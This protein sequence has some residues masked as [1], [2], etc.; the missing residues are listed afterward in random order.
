MMNPIRTRFS[1][2]L[3]VG[4]LGANVA[5][6]AGRGE[7]IWRSFLETGD[8]A[9]AIE[10]F[11]RT[12]E[13]DADDLMA[14]AGRAYL[15]ECRVEEGETLSAFLDALENG[16]SSPEAP[17]FL[18]EAYHRVSGREDAAAMLERLGALLQRD[19]LVSHV[20]DRALFARAQLLQK[21]GKWSDAETAF[22]ELNFL[23][24]FWVC[25]P[26]DNTEK[27][28]HSQ[29]YGPEESLDLSATS[30]GRRRDV[31]WRPLLVDPYDGYIDLHASVQPAQES[32]VYLAS[33]VNSPSDQR[34]KL[35]LGYAGAVKAWLN[36]V[37][38][39]D[40]NRY[41]AALPDQAEAA[42]ELREG[43]NT[44]LVKVSAPKEGAFGLYARFVADEELSE[45]AL[46]T[47]AQPDLKNDTPKP[48]QQVNDDAFLF[49]ATSIKQLKAFG[50]NA[51]RDPQRTLFYVR[52]LSLLETADQNDQSTNALMGAMCKRYPGNPLLLRHLGD[53][54]PQDNRQRLAYDLV[55]ESDPDDLAAFMGLLNYY[56]NSAYA[57]KG[58]ELIREW[59]K[60]HKV[61]LSARL[62]QAQM[63]RKQ[64]LGEAAAGLLLQ[65][66]ENLGGEGL[67]LL[68]EFLGDSVSRE[69]QLD[70]LKR[71]LEDDPM[72]AEVVHTLRRIALRNGNLDSVDVF[73]KHEN[74]IDPF[75][76]TGL[77]D[78]ALYYQSSGNDEAALRTL[79]D[80]QRI[81]PDD[82]Q[83]HRMTAVANHALGNEAKAL[84]ALARAQEILPSDPWCIDYQEML[85]PDEEN[86]AA[87]YLRDWREVE[88][89][90]SLDLSKANYLT[91]LSQ[92]IVKVFPN[93]NSS[94]T[95]Q[96]AVTVLTD[97]GVRM[98]QVRP[99][100]YEAG[101]EDVVVKRARVHKPDGSAFDAPPARKQSASSA[102]DAQARLYMDYMVA[103]LQFPALEKGCT[104]EL[105]YEVVSKNDNIFAD[106]FGDQFYIGDG[107][108]EPTAD[109][110]YVLITPQS[111][112]FYWKYIGP[113]YPASVLAGSPP[114]LQEEPVVKEENG[115]RA[116]Q[117][118]YTNLPA[119][120]REPLM[121]AAVE[122]LP[123]IKISTFETWSDMSDWYWNLIEDQLEPGPVVKERLEFVLQEYRRKRGLGQ[124]RE[125]TDWEKVRAVNE[126]VNTGIRYLGLE[127][128][129]DGFKPHKVDEICNAQY[130]D[131]KDKAALAVAMLGELGIE[132][133]MVILR[134]TDKGEI[135][136]ELPSLNLFNHAIYYLPDLDGKDYWIDGTA[137]FFD[138]S[139]LPPGDQ[140][141]YSL[142]IEPGGE[143][144]FKRIRFSEAA[145]NGGEYTTALR[146]DEDGNAEGIRISE[147]RGLYNPIV[148]RTYENETKAKEVVERI[149][150]SRYPGGSSS[151]IDLSNLEDYATSERLA[152]ELA[153][154]QF[155]TKQANSLAFPTTLFSD[156][157]SQRYAQ[158]TNR[159]YDLVLSYPWTRTN[160]TRFEMPKGGDAIEVPSDRTIES[161]FGDYT[162]VITVDGN[163]IEIREELKFLPVRVEKD[164]YGEFREFCRL[165]DLYQSE[166][167]ILNQ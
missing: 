164:K 22:G 148:R 113:N 114:E 124:E 18:L 37:L 67:M 11:D 139:E 54:E 85:Q 60:D 40:V 71:A 141:S 48:D 129:I 55:L 30:P 17:L 102:A 143:Y 157:L 45:V 145:D 12:L 26:F 140:G 21:L 133:R 130:G 29:A 99:I 159:E 138:A 51:G 36:G 116:Y 89:P 101:T 146:I 9:A 151:N 14:Q 13:E 154:P 19:D 121:P 149:L 65:Y 39:M 161:E 27:R 105:E 125:L 150:V 76:V 93:G 42:C 117:W 69:Q 111:R 100:Y 63:L 134:T 84:Q 56:R 79:A 108:Y 122:V 131:C 3:L 83:T 137:T 66:E 128:G 167:V 31:T 64:G 156:D 68:L 112:A 16:A 28:G 34:V 78:L 2:L 94:R 165:V 53:T 52:M 1:I 59:E 95:V 58:F 166:N 92:T 44:L 62:L 152:Y 47:D 86:Y 49:E 110:E 6:S 104:I 158:L 90:A 88:P 32:T 109:T 50:E 10:G 25:G 123:Y 98:Q 142:I 163:N 147:F 144:F 155:G 127:F 153:I 15:S 72:N 136:Y 87:P 107:R 81:T 132:A 103:V 77:M 96:E 5:W 160:I 120:P 41:H 38:V 80:I 8:V 74:R 7:I 126:Y 20:S 115:E 106:F 35:S 61:P 118:R 91:L 97:T 57:T 24:Q 33:Q 82:F 119:L 70:I 4:L 73:I 162:R 46:A 43:R 75:S 135:D 23:T